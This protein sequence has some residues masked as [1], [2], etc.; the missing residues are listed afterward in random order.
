MAKRQQEKTEQTKAAMKKAAKILFLEKGYEETSIQ[1]ISALSSYSVGS[2]YRHWK[3]K[4]QIFMEIWDEYVADFIRESVMNATVSM[5]QEA[6]IRF[7]LNRSEQFTNDPMSKKLSLTSHMLSAT[8]EYEGVSTWFHK[9]SMMLY[10]FLKGCCPNGDDMKLKS[11][12]NIIHC[13]L[14]A[15]AM[16]ETPIKVPRYEFDRETLYECIWA[17][18]ENCKNN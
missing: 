4:Q 10:L 14:N 2:Y 11:T 5:D 18:V 7:L 15:D 13:I 6:M 1:E 3:S 12:A 16:R 8:Y 17:L 9:Y